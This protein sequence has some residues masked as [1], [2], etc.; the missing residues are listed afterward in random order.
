MG[1]GSSLIYFFLFYTPFI[2]PFNHS[3]THN[4]FLKVFFLYNC[5]LSKMIV[6]VVSKPKISHW[7]PRD[8]FRAATQFLLSFFLPHF[9]QLSLACLSLSLEYI[10]PIC[11]YIVFHQPHKSRNY[12]LQISEMSNKKYATICYVNI[13]LLHTLLPVP[14]SI[15][16]LFYTDFYLPF[17]KTKKH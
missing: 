11:W 6:T 1:H 7:Q 10:L 12:W 4:I 13:A 5:V 16:K 15:F 14:S 3:L 8:V 17:W 9:R 2:Y